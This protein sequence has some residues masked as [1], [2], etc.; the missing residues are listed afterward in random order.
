MQTG[1][2]VRLLPLLA[3]LVACVLLFVGACEKAAPAPAPAPAASKLTVAAAASVRYALAEIIAEFEKANKGVSVEG[4]YG[5]SGS[6]FQQI[7]SKAP[8]DVFLSADEEYATELVKQRHGVGGSIVRYATGR[9]VL[10]VPKDSTL[11]VSKGL[12]SLSDESVKKIAIANPTLAPYGVA[13]EES[14]RKAGIYETVKDRLVLGENITQTAQFVESGAAQ[15]GLI[16]LSMI[17]APGM[18]DKGRSWTVPESD[19]SPIIQS[20]C[21]S[22]YA[23]DQK[24]AER[25][26]QF[27][28]SE[29]SRE[30]LRRH[31]FGILGE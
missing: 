9:L 12:P 4:V 3:L 29:P 11:D 8:F 7:A 21:I 16:A 22:A 2:P 19:H 20:G 27:L 13:A 1:H 6:L 15:A 30:I 25:F 10:W 23:K 26:M 31:G 5:A 24:L 17:S 28:A 14:L 18:K